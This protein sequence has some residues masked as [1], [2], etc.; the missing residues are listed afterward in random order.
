M[1]IKRVY[2]GGSVFITPSVYLRRLSTALEYLK[3]TGKTG[4]G[5][6]NRNSAQAIKRGGGGK[7]MFNLNEEKIEFALGNKELCFG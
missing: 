7:K 4:T 3:A 5:P 6:T 1:L 2:T